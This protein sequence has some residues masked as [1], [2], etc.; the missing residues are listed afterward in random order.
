MSYLYHLSL[1]QFFHPSY[2]LCSK[3]KEVVHI[4]IPSPIMLI[5]RTYTPFHVIEHWGWFPGR[6]EGTMVG[7]RKKRGWGFATMQLS[8]CR[9]LVAEGPSWV[10]LTEIRLNCRLRWRYLAST[11]ACS[12]RGGVVGDALR[13]QVAAYGAPGR[14]GYL[15]GRY[16]AAVFR[17]RVKLRLEC[18]LSSTECL[19]IRYSGQE[20]AFTDPGEMTGPE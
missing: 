19:A 20:M 5:V 3:Q 18:R 2:M 8:Q 14:R 1:M 7:R 11:N 15:T 9:E 16:P 17:L 10:G 13:I 6:G 12:P 4:T